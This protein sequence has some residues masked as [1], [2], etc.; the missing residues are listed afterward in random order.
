M[1]DFSRRHSCESDQWLSQCWYFLSDVSLMSPDNGEEDPCLK[2]TFSFSCNDWGVTAWNILAVKVTCWTTWF[3]FFDD[4]VSRWAGS[5]HYKTKEFLFFSGDSFPRLISWHDTWRSTWWR[6]ATKEIAVKEVSLCRERCCCCCI[7]HMLLLIHSASS[8]TGNDV[9]G[10]IP[11]EGLHLPRQE[12]SCLTSCI[13]KQINLSWSP[14][15]CD[16]R[17]VHQSM[18][19]STHERLRGTLVPLFPNF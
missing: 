19:S 16:C 10:R 13:S 18:L 12:T 8:P 14:F 5:H 11:I 7:L 6:R 1:T 17:T 15:T 3:F 2:K 9:R 4:K